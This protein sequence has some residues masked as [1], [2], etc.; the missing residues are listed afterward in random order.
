M[1]TYFDDIHMYVFILVILFSGRL[2]QSITTPIVCL[3]L[4]LLFLLLLLLRLLLFCLLRFFFGFCLCLF[5]FLLFILFLFAF[6]LLRLIKMCFS[7][8]LPFYLL[9]SFF[10]F[11]LSS[12]KRRWNIFILFIYDFFSSFL[13]FLFL[14][15]CCRLFCSV[16]FFAA[17]CLS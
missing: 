11:L 5:A 17:L 6:R 2:F 9:L 3:S 14:R 15:V 7:P 10:L 16:L 1:C 13:F 12:S 4:L 8:S